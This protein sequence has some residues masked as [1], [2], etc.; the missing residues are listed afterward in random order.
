MD[1]DTAV[2]ALNASVVDLTL[3]LFAW[4][5]YRPARTLCGVQLLFLDHVCNSLNSVVHEHAMRG[6]TT[7]AGRWAMYPSEKAVVA[8]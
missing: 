1:V 6:R 3:S 7:R 5:K 2:Y 8:L 4:V